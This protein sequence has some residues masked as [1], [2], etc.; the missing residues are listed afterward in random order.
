MKTRIAFT[1]GVSLLLI[2]G[3]AVAGEEKE[4]E[5]IVLLQEFAVYAQ[6]IAG[7]EESLKALNEAATEKGLA[8][9]WDV[10]A[11]DDMRYTISIWVDGLTGL[12]VTGGM[13]EAFTESWGKENFAKWNDK[14]HATFEHSKTSLWHPRE[15]L[16]YM[17]ENMPKENDF[18]YWG[19]L[20]VK[21]GHMKGVEEGFKKFAQLMTEHE[22]PSGW[23]TAVGGL[24]TEGP[25]LGYL[26]WGASAG[27][28]FTLVD[29]IESNE[30]LMEASAPVWEEMLPHIRGFEYV[31]GKYRKDLSYHP[32]KKAE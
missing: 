16:S 4:S 18:F 20:S 27:A 15:D 6:G 12:E 5:Q 8:Y 32:E 25:V 14:F 1:V 7:F 3:L 2:V 28:F 17:P 11:A 13:W 10:Y 30:E 23:R 9:G 26:E 29:K 21:P 24:G 19:T 31:T 22:V